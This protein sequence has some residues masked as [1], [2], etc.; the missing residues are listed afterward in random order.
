MTG[1]RC[2]DIGMQCGFEVKNGSSKDEVM[3]IATVH[4]K[5]AHGIHTV[6]ADLASKIS[7]AIR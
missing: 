5:A 7:S 6:P 2:A 4:A 1:F 3:Q